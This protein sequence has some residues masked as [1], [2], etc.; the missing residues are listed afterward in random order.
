MH[1]ASQPRRAPAPRPHLAALP[2]CAHGS[3]CEAEL[4]AHGLARERLLD[5]SASINPLGPSPRVLEALQALTAGEVARYPDDGSP[6]LRAELAGRAE[7]GV[8]QIMVANGSIELLWLL[9]L[10]YLAPGDSVLVIGPTF[11]EYAR[12]AQVVGAT[13]VEWRAEASAG[14]VLDLAALMAQIERQRPRLVFLCNPNNPTGVCLDR[15]AI[16]GLLETLDGALLVVDEAYA[17][18]ADGSPALT[19]LLSDGRLVLLRSLTKTYGLAGLRLGYVLGAPGVIEALD[20]VRPP[21][22]VNAA[23]LACGLAALRDPDHLRLAL[24]EVGRSRAYLTEALTDLGLRVYPPTTNFV[25]VDVGDGRAFRDRLLPRGFCVRDG[26]SFGLP[27]CVRIGVRAYQDCAQLLATVRE[28][29]GTMPEADLVAAREQTWHLQ[30][31]ATKWLR[32]TDTG[33]RA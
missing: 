32:S 20:R 1:E 25:L 13:V 7:V 3:I 12:A 10:A 27:R 17:P 5:F 30:A 22:T 26:A 21:W 19:D 8:E 4:L 6:A 15:T 31:A 11:G 28:V 14:F 24:V 9:A 33:G 18:F 29:L 16:A 2:A 23:A